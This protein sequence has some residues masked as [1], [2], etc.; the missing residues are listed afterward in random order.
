MY[1]VFVRTWWKRNPSWPNGLEPSP[2]RKT[3]IKRRVNTLD[4]ARQ[5]VQQYNATHEPGRLSKKAEFEET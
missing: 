4:E 2:G 3:Y 5:I 1:A